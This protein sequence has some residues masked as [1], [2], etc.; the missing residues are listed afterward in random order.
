[1]MITIAE[2]SAT[3]IV[4]SILS[5]HGVGLSESNLQPSYRKKTEKVEKYAALRRVREMPHIKFN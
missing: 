5:Y 3:M 4:C 2:K 1:M